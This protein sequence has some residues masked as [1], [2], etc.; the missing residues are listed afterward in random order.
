[1]K[2]D[3]TLAPGDPG[4]RLRQWEPGSWYAANLRTGET[5]PLP[6]TPSL[7]AAIGHFNASLRGT[8]RRAAA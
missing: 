6:A 7:L 3:L 4:W 5:R 1:M 8:G 2:D